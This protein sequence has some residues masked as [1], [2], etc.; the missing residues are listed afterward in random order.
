MLKPVPTPSPET[1][2]YWD[3]AAT[4]ELRYT[5]CTPCGSALFPPRAKCPA[6][7]EQT[8]WRLS[9]GKG[10][11]HSVSQVF[12]APTEAFRPDVPYFIALVDLEEGFRIMVNVHREEASIG[13]KVSIM[14]EDS[15]EGFKLPQA[16]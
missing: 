8:E 2:P 6:C 10:E 5:I 16:I 4:G 9:A 14:F 3:G 7:H 13:D 15:A 11:I 12:R 1:Q